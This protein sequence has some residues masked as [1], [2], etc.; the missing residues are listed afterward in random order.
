MFA[1]DDGGLL[2][3]RRQ[4]DGLSPIRRKRR[5]ST[6]SWK[7]EI[8]IEAPLNAESILTMKIGSELTKVS[9]FSMEFWEKL[10][11]DGAQ[12]EKKRIRIKLV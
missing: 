4:F 6:E 7:L 10:S 2:N 12:L 5:G 11:H 1:Q 3:R 8:A 9:I